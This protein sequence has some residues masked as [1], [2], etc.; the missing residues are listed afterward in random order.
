[1]R[2]FFRAIAHWVI[3]GLA[4]LCTNSTP[5]TA[6]NSAQGK[7]DPI[8]LDIGH[9][10]ERYGATSARGKKEYDYNKRFTIELSDKLISTVH[11]STE[12]ISGKDKDLSLNQRAK[13]IRSLRSGIFLSLHHDSVQPRYLSEWSY[14]G[15]KHHYSDKFAGFSVFASGR[16]PA[17]L[18]SVVL[19]QNIGQALVKAGFSPTLHHAE[20]ITGENRPLLNEDIGLYRYDGLAVLKSTRIPAILVEVGVIA[21]RAEEEKLGDPAHRAKIQDAI[22]LGLKQFCSEI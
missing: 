4:G 3:I 7:C 20:K 10:A 15:Q 21:N 2:R 5:A 6:G 8:Y 12:I 22:L 14:N 13:K 16:S 11:F 17:F 19:G 1:L 18:K 9:T